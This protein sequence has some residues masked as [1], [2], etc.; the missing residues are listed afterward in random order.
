[1]AKRNDANICNTNS[2]CRV[3]KSRQEKKEKMESE[4]MMLPIETYELFR[5]VCNTYP[6]L[7]IPMT[8]LLQR[9]G[10]QVFGDFL[11]SMLQTMNEA[12]NAQ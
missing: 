5:L 12:K 8:E 10:K 2:T 1:M 6:H 11:I 3:R 7:E 4:K 9:H